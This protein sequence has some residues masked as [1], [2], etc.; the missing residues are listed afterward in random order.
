MTSTLHFGIALVL[1]SDWMNA[2]IFI[3]YGPQSLAGHS[4]VQV[5]LIPEPQEAFM[6]A[7]EQPALQAD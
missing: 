1:V 5:A 7:P 3:M 2:G 4:Q 6:A